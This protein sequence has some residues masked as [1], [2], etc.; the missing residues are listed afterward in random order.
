LDRQG[1]AL[2]QF[3][4]DRIFSDK[5]S[6]KTTAR[7]GLKALLDFVRE[8][9]VLHIESISR[10]ARSTTDLL[11]ES[12]QMDSTH[13]SVSENRKL[14]IR[15]VGVLRGLVLYVQI[16]KSLVGSPRSRL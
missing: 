3:I 5:G 7:P 14:N 16:E 9:D 15:R 12:G 4:P 13:R 2:R 10:L 8:G 1:D 11:H 6:G